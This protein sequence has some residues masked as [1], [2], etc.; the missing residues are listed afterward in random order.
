MSFSGKRAVMQGQDVTYITERC[1]MR[2]TP[3]GLVVTEIAPG[4][5]IERDI[6][7]LSAVPLKIA[8]NASVMD[9]KLFRP[10]KI[11]M[12]IG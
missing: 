2:L 1:V 4:I 8:E 5:E 10:G 3:E 11:G 9:P 7:P 6:L 12:E